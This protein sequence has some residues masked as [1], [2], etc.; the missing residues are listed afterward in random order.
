MTPLTVRLDLADPD[1]HRVALATLPARW[2]ITTDPGADVVA[3]SGRGRDWPATAAAAIGAGARG[4]LVA[5]PEPADVG[6]LRQLEETRAVVAVESPV[7]DATWLDTVDSVRA[8]VSAASLVHG[9]AVTDRDLASGLVEQVT[10]I[11]SLAGS[12]DEVR[13][14][15]A[16]RTSYWISAT[17]AGTPV[18]L[19]GVESPVGTRLTVDVVAE[20]EQWV[21]AFDGSAAAR[22]T[23]VAHYDAHGARL[24]PDRHESAERAVWRH[25]AAALT[26]GAP[27]PYTVGDLAD[28]LEPLD[29]VERLTGSG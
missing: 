27:L 18:S 9:L 4:V 3:V 16:D 25:L 26:E 28:H 15:S 5:A 10:L 19:A 29:P 22:P 23:A 12:L 7:F 13:A 24:A 20:H 21:A 8:A 11:G 6:A 17:V 1:R 14:G 2:C